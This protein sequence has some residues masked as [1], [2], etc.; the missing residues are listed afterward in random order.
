[1][2]IPSQT[3][4]LSR[5]H[6]CIRI[7]LLISTLALPVVFMAGKSVTGDEIAHLPAGYSYL[8]TGRVLLNPMHP[9]LIKELCALPLRF[10]HPRMPLDA[11]T[12]EKRATDFTYQ[13]PFG[14][15]FF[16]Q[17]GRDRLVFWG[18][19]P[20]VLLSF[21]LAIV[22]LNWA[23]ELWGP[24]GGSLA[25]F[26]YAFDPTIDAHSQLVTTDVGFAFFSVLF[27]Y[28]L[29]RYV[30]EPDRPRLI[31]AGM[32]LGLALGAKFSGVLLVPLAALLLATSAAFGAEAEKD[33][34]PIALM[35]PLA[36]RLLAAC[37][38]FLSLLI[39]AYAVLWIIYLLPSDPFFYLKGLYTV[40]ADNDPHFQSF[41]MGRLYSGRELTYFPI[42]WLIKTPIPSLVIIVA[43]IVLFLRGRRLDRIDELFLTVPA[44]ALFVGYSL[45]ADQIGVR[46]LIPC[47]PLFFIFAARVATAT[48]RRGSLAL[49]ALLVWYLAEFAAVSPDHLS[50]FNQI[51]GGPSGG[52][53]W[54]DDSNVDWGQGL[55]QLRSYLQDHPVEHYHLCCF[56]CLDPKSYGVDGE[57]IRISG[58]ISPPSGI[59]ILSAHCV[60]RLRPWLAERYGDSP[61]NW[62]AHKSPK[63]IVGH[64]Y[65]VYDL[66]S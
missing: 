52:V 33:R 12:L 39:T 23:T 27:L 58:L 37:G 42:A 31:I 59:Q 26:L 66:D 4:S 45:F 35:R 34:E 40:Q 3:S 9:P 43:S 20:A 19:M 25:L 60:A 64:A 21:G 28:T 41:L 38:T 18:R 11:D 51:A 10:L 36:G 50:Y 61:Q 56:G 54:L 13:W 44:L 7:M 2:D 22:V 14:H 63:A 49:G 62:M 46:Y 5:S 30:R 57:P 29:R 17:P 48:S 53:R 47:F 8:V 24:L 15:Q 32:T 55:I 65:Y 6:R 1:M 16:A